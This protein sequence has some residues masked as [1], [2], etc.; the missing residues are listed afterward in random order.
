M[1]GVLEKNIIDTSEVL[2]NKE[3]IN[4]GYLLDN[5]LIVNSKEEKL[6]DTLKECLLE[7]EKFYFS[8][9][10]INFSGLQL[11][12]DTFK[13]L[14]E[15]GVR[16]EIITSTYLNFTEP[17]AL[18]KIKNFNNIKLKVFLATREKGF[19]TKV[20]I[21]ENKKEFKVIIGSSNITQNAL[22]NN[23]EWNVKIVSKEDNTFIK[24]VLEEYINLWNSTKE[25][26]DDFIKE[27]EEFIKKIRVAEK[28]TKLYFKDYEI[29]KPN[30]MQ[31]RALENL[32]KL[33][34]AGENKALVIASTGTGKTFMAAFD[35][36]NFKPKKMLFLVHREEILRSAEKT[37][38]RLSK[39][40]NYTM[41]LLTST[42]KEIDRQYIFSSIQS[43]NINLERFSKK[44]FDYII[45]DEAHHCT[46]SS[47][48]KV[49]N[50]FKPKFLLGMTATPERADG[51][52]IFE[53]FDNNIALEVRLHE[54]LDLNLV[55][56]FH[57]FGITDIKDIDLS[58]VNIDDL[59]KV[60]KILSI[61]KRV[62]FIIE[63]MSFYG[64][65]GIKRKCIGF[66]AN[67]EHAKYMAE[68]FNKRGIK[69]ACL[70]G[71]DSPKF[72]SEVIEKLESDENDLEV[73]FTVD[74]FNE[75][76]DI[77]AINLILMLRPT[78]S[79]IVFIQ[80]LGRG[81]RKYKDKTFL[82]VL[83]FIG[84]YNKA[85]LIAMA[86]KGS[87]YYDKDSLKV[88][89]A[90]NFSDIPGCT[91]IEMDRIAKERI[92]EQI[93]NEK[94]NSFKY[95]KEQYLEFKKM[96]GGEI[97]YLL[98]D[99][100]KYDGAPD[101]IKFLV[102]EK[103]YLNFIQRI[104]K[105]SKLNKILCNDNFV[106][107]ITLLTK[108]LPI[109][110]PYEFIILKYLLYKNCINIEEVKKETLKYMDSVDEESIEHAL[111]CLNGDFYDSSEK[112]SNIK[113]FLYNEKTLYKNNIFND[114][115]SDKQYKIYIED[116]INYGLIRYKKEFGRNNYGT[117]FL[118]LYE[119]YKMKDIALLSNYNKT[120]SS[121]RGS[122]LLTN[123]NEY[124]LFI[125]LHKETDIKE[126]INYKDKFL[127]RDKFQWQSPNLTS[128]SSNRGKNIIYNEKRK[129]NLHLFV[130]K[131]KEIDRV[132]QPYV[133]IGTG[134][135]ITFQ[136]EKPITII[137]NLKYKVPKDLYIE[138]NEKV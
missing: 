42:R 20:Y 128:Q 8:V 80:Q 1:D 112:I 39:N 51:D 103:T 41:G 98:L 74:I 40:K 44:E 75:G 104:E 109:K 19:H 115:L 29:I 21:F 10:F 24:D 134:N 113:L 53:A 91:N 89:V 131:Y 86:L 61:N 99:Y 4:T 43:M 16:G 114:I 65:D 101:P 31:K 116:I 60:A 28:N 107:I 2:Q 67:I 85:F 14:E 121:F 69:S 52:S 48:K 125:D 17:K 22:K 34:E 37:F 73:I 33:R 84:N 126:S 27:Y 137:F 64:F 92:L 11:L 23:I 138:F 97:P 120:H 81:L 15:K 96:N 26:D 82:T 9:A 94:F 55:I 54:A 79:P 132:S 12:L 106:K 70:T 56:P 5:K 45:V 77:P 25:I 76:V 110:R 119:Q 78:N 136:G 88:A 3:I 127:S 62:D 123:G 38:K 6:L 100:L 30:D 71:N 57:Y 63:K 122:G 72:R 50:Y 83:D 118:K 47:Y 90:N 117:P 108:Y 32:N 124:F 87:R 130:R 7:C 129:I 105:D 133:Y 95:L 49:M 135:T 58:D 35:V 111:R 13:E 18:E 46:S 93:N 68:E 59:S 36:L 66:C 102:K